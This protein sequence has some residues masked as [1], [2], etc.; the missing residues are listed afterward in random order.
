[1]AVL[2]VADCMADAEVD[3]ICIRKLEGPTCASG[4]AREIGRFDGKTQSMAYIK[5]PKSHMLKTHKHTR[6]HLNIIITMMILTDSTMIKIVFIIQST[7][8]L[9]LFLLPFLFYLSLLPSL[10]ICKN[11]NE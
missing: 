4:E 2:S 9:L 8:Q 10:D 6:T 7:I 3:H 5:K 1:M 11:E